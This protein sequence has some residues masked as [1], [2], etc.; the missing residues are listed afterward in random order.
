MGLRAVSRHDPRRHALRLLN[1]ILGENMSSRLFQVVREEHGLTYNIQSSA[2]TWA[3]VGDLVVSAGLD[4]SEVE[5]TLVLVIREL[6]R[7]MKRAPGSAELTRAKDY[8]LGQFE[9]SMESTENHMM[10][11]GEQWLNQGEFV[12]PA[13]IR[14]R[15]TKVTAQEISS[16]A[17]ALFTP[18]RRSLAI[19]SPRKQFSGLA[20]ILAG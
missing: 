19:V 16:V 13:V 6:N 7:L 20:R 9:L 5:K 2:T 18:D 1:V 4:P 12:P 10:W 11:L 8:V 14:D 17:R 3:D 15:I